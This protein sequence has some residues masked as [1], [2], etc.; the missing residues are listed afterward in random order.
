MFASSTTTLHI[1]FD[2][3][4]FVLHC[5]LWVNFPKYKFDYLIF[6]LKISKFL[7]LKIDHIYLFGIKIQ[8]IILPQIF[9]V[10][11]LLFWYIIDHSSSNNLSFNKTSYH[12]Q[13]KQ[14]ISCSDSVCFPCWTP[15]ISENSAYF[16]WKYFLEESHTFE[17]SVVLCHNYFIT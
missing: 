5:S 8:F 10:V 1:L 9:F 7:L 12:C 15:Y 3:L 13:P 2:L 4:Q 17:I 11:C 16:P 6:V 14:C